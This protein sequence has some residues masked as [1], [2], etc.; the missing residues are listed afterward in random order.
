MITWVLLA[1]FMAA[2]AP[3]EPR[4]GGIVRKVNIARPSLEAN[5]SSKEFSGIIREAAEVN[6]AFRVAGPIG[7]IYVKEGDFVRQGDLVARIEPRDYEIPP[8]T[9]RTPSRPLGWP[10]P[11]ASICSPGPKPKASTST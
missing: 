5:V 10:S 6:L 4:Q 1:A 7:E 2:C 3:S 11:R 9:A 8:T